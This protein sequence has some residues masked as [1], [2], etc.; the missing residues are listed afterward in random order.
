MLT[1]TTPATVTRLTTLDEVRH[2]LGDNFTENSDEPRVL[3]LIDRATALIER[4]TNRVFSYQ[5]YT[6]TRA[7]HGQFHLHL[8]RVPLVELTAATFDGT[9]YLTDIDVQSRSTGRLYLDTSFVG[10]RVFTG[11]IVYDPY[12]LGE[13]SWSFSYTAGFKLPEDNTTVA[14]REVL[15]KDVQWAATMLCSWLF[16]RKPDQLNVKEIKVGEATTTYADADES[17]T[18]SGMPSEVA[19]ILKPWRLRFF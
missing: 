4:Y 18:P 5:T 2:E 9:S 13:E 14:N 8:E 19:D 11:P 1:V 3:R 6:E 16:L 10:T 12:E 7:T 17:P 15:P